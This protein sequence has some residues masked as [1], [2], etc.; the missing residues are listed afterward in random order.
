VED[1]VEKVVVFKVLDL[2]IDDFSVTTRSIG[3]MVT[4]I[5]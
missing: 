5:A 2:R 1:P 3:N 4:E